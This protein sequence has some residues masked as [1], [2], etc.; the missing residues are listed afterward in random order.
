[1]PWICSCEGVREWCT[2]LGG[3]PGGL[4]LSEHDRT[5]KCGPKPQILCRH[6]RAHLFV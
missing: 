1:M 5:E 2:V 3:D 4:D 6:A